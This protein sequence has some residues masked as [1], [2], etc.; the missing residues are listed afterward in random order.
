MDA[1][2][3]G[4]DHHLVSDLAIEVFFLIFIDLNP[5]ISYDDHERNNV[6]DLYFYEN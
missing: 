2:E 6:H 1:L 3:T 4:S 5:I